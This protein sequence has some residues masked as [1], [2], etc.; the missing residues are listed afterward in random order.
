EGIFADVTNDGGTY[1][2]RNID[3]NHG[4]FLNLFIDVSLTDRL[5]L[6][7][8]RQ[9]LLYGAQRLVSPLDW[10]NP[11]RTFEG[12]RLLLAGGDWKSDA[13]FTYFVP[14]D[15]HDFDEADDGQKFYGLY[16]TYTGIE[17]LTLDAYYLGYDNEHPTADGDFSVHTLGARLYYTTSN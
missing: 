17:R 2:P 8:G 15:P 14:P 12:A 10:S 9:E 7:L 11:R 1:V 4:D 5:T 13:F 3:R 16:N 6:R